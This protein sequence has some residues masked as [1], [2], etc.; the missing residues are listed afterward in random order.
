MGLLDPCK[1]KKQSSICGAVP[2]KLL[3]NRAREKTPCNEVQPRCR[4]KFQLRSERFSLS[5]HGKK[6]E[7]SQKSLCFPISS[8]LL[9]NYGRGVYFS[10]YPSYSMT[11]IRGASRLLLCQVL[12]GKVYRCSKLIHGEPLEMGHDCH[13]SP[14]GKELVIFN[15]HHILPSYVVHYGEATGDFTYETTKA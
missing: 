9:G 12:P 3:W 11:F 2:F 8:L 15:S 14:D 5:R 10:E 1:C 6:E 13:T 7:E 4:M